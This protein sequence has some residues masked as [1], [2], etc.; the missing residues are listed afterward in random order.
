M[1]ATHLNIGSNQGCRHENIQRAAALIE[2]LDGVRST[3]CSEVVES[4][5][6]GYDSPNRFLNM[7][8]LVHTDM[9]PAQLLPMLL[10]IQNSISPDP[11]RNP[12][13]TYADRIVDIDI[14]AS[15][16][17]DAETPVVYSDS[18]LTVPHPLMHCRDFVLLPLLQLEPDWRHPLSGIG[19]RQLLINVLTKKS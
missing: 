16:D 2:H 1:F 14:I 8:M 13:G 9:H 19:G 11:H 4:E 6:W 3:R 15:H 7:G 10:E 5:P 12:D 18:R 17:L